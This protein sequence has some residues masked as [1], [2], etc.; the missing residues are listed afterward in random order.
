MGLPIG[1]IATCLARTYDPSTPAPE[2]SRCQAFL[3]SIG[4]SP[5]ATEI[6]LSLL[7]A[8]PPDSAGNTSLYAC[9]FS[10]QLLIAQV[11]SR[12]NLQPLSPIRERCEKLFASVALSGQ[13]PIVSRYS[14]LVAAIAVLEWP[15]RWPGLSALLSGDDAFA[16]W[17]LCIASIASEISEAILTADF[18]QAKEA[19]FAFSQALTGGLVRQAVGSFLAQ[20]AAA[21]ELLLG[22]IEFWKGD[23]ESS[24]EQTLG[25]AE[26]VVSFFHALIRDASAPSLE[27]LCAL[28]DRPLS[29]RVARSLIEMA[30]EVARSTATLEDPALLCAAWCQTVAAQVPQISPLYCDSFVQVA[31]AMLASPLP[32][33]QIAA[34]KVWLKIAGSVAPTELPVKQLLSAVAAALGSETVAVIG[35][36]CDLPQAASL[37]LQLVRILSVADP[38]VACESLLGGCVAG[39]TAANKKS[40]ALL[41]ALDAATGSLLKSEPALLKAIPYY[42]WT[43]QE[44]AKLALPTRE[45]RQA[46]FAF[47]LLRYLTA[48]LRVTR[49]PTNALLQRVV[50]LAYD[51]DDN[52]NPVMRGKCIDAFSTF[53]E[54]LQPFVDRDGAIWLLQVALPLVDPKAV[55]VQ[56]DVAA[57]LTALLRGLSLRWGL[58][59]GVVDAVVAAHLEAAC[60]QLKGASIRVLAD[61]SG[62][63]GAVSL[64]RRGNGDQ[65]WMEGDLD[66]CRVFSTALLRLTAFLKAFQCSMVSAEVANAVL[67][68]WHLLWQVPKVLGGRGVLEDGDSRGDGT[69][70]GFL[71]R[72]G[73]W[74]DGAVANALG[75]LKL[76]ATLR[77]FRE[78]VLATLIGSADCCTAL[79]VATGLLEDEDRLP[80]SLV[81][82]AMQ[83]ACNR[84]ELA[85][86]D[87]M[88][89][90]CERTACAF[91]CAIVNRLYPERD[92]DVATATM[93]LQLLNRLSGSSAIVRILPAIGRWCSAGEKRNF[94][95]PWPELAAALLHAAAESRDL[96]SVAAFLVA[97]V[98][99]KTLIALTGGHESRDHD[100]VRLITRD[101]HR[102]AKASSRNTNHPHRLRSLLNGEFSSQTEM[103]IDTSQEDL[104]L[105]LLFDS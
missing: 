82:D 25:S 105:T 32:A 46:P 87:S 52:Q 20:P 61:L 51:F 69:V 41:F 63:S 27:L 71:R 26:A 70:R 12:Q 89:P 2:R 83:Q 38:I 42:R 4:E 88:A 66:R 101:L 11:T 75:A 73:A 67:Q 1:E 94:P 43:S 80:A 33:L 37:C 13:R 93:T 35:R 15:A 64:A 99:A 78:R 29:T 31:I 79:D 22:T 24:I 57:P 54:V 9:T 3:A 50:E 104:S 19:S 36:D 47:F 96:G 90:K 77:E 81:M 23:D 34:S 60:V 74:Y 48:C 95:V 21:L 17:P 5:Q 56:L 62:V 16:S 30:G 97:R 91:Y 65:R 6:A 92:G 7:E 59:V 72:F 68:W 98:D 14:R 53:F 86:D 49:Q 55:A 10:F 40:S 18:A 85:E 58:G 28:G 84:L 100:S 39:V 8:F 45:P 103:K 102:S 44:L 76:I